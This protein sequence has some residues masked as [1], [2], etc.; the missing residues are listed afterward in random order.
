MNEL[1]FSTKCLTHTAIAALKSA[2]EGC[3]DNAVRDSIV[4]AYKAMIL[5][6]QDLGKFN[7][8]DT[9]SESENG[10]DASEYCAAV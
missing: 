6:N 1:N 10:I 4:T 9:T 2:Y 7:S 3:S 5:L 8:D